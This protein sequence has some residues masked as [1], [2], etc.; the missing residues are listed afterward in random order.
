MD[1]FCVKRGAPGMITVGGAHRWD[2]GSVRD[3]YGNHGAET[4]ESARRL[5]DYRAQAGPHSP[6]GIVYGI[7]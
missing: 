1:G 5:R 3:G 2:Y 6:E 4:G 7:R